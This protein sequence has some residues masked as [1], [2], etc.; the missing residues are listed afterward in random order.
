MSKEPTF[1]S[2]HIIIFSTSSFQES[3]KACKEKESIAHSQR[4]SVSVEAQTF[5]A[6]FKSTVLDLLKDKGE[7]GQG[8]KGNQDNDV[9][10][11]NQQSF[12]K[13]TKQRH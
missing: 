3:Y 7:Q 13:G 5:S 8:A 12:Q 2:Y 10:T 1:Q 11:E 6:D 4:E 9:S